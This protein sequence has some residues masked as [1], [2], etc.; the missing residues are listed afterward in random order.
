MK[1]VIVYIIWSEEHRGWWRS[2]HR[3]YTQKREEAGQYDFE[4]AEA[5]VLSANIQEND[6]PNEAIVPI[7]V[8]AS[9]FGTGE[10]VK[11]ERVYANEPHIADI[12][13]EQCPDCGE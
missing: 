8:C 10:V 7:K 13:V 6:V 12:G 3:G 2:N 5:I 9:C 4:E 1:K 11:G